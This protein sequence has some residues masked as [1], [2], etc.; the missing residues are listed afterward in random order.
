MRFVKLVERFPANAPP[1][2]QE[3]ERVVISRAKEP[4]LYHIWLA[5]GNKREIAALGNTP[6]VIK[7]I[8]YEIECLLSITNQAIQKGVQAMLVVIHQA[9]KLFMRESL[10]VMRV[11]AHVV[12]FAAISAGAVV[13]IIEHS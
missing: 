1:A 11:I 5:A 7:R 6:G 13:R 12:S 8:L 10:R 3:R 4:A 2:A 9:N